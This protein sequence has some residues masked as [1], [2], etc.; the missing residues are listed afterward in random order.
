MSNAITSSDSIELTDSNGRKITYR[1]LGVFE[2]AMMRKAAGIHSGN[3]LYMRY[4]MIACGIRAIDGQPRPMPV[5]ERSIDAA[6]KEMGDE[7]FFAFVKHVQG[8]LA[9]EEGEPG[10]IANDADHAAKQGAS[11]KK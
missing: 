2:D 6:I 9:T 7:G 8:Q 1:E 10:A 5:N 4:A 3:E 11:L